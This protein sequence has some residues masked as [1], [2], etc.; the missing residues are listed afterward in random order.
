MPLFGFVFRTFACPF[1]PRPSPVQERAQVLGADAA[2]R[3]DLLARR[4]AAEA[5]ALDAYA[6]RTAAGQAA[7]AQ[8]RASNNDEYRALRRKCATDVQLLALSC[9]DCVI[10]CWFELHSP[11]VSDGR[12]KCLRSEA[13]TQS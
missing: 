11:F 2:V 9:N 8:L 3:D 6:A 7:L 10:M 4:D 1:H 12:R 13:L 5:A